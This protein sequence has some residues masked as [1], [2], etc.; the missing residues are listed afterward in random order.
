MADYQE[1]QKQKMANEGYCNKI[2]IFFDEHLSGDRCGCGDRALWELVQNAC[3]QSQEARVEIEL[4]DR[5]LIFKHHGRAFDYESFYSLVKQDSSKD[6]NADDAEKSV[7]RYG[8]G[9]MTTHTFNKLVKVSG[10]YIVKDYVDGTGE[11]KEVIIRGHVQI[12]DFELDRT[13]IGTPE[14]PSVMGRQLN[15]VDKFRDMEMYSSIIDNTTSFRYDL[16]PGQVAIVSR[17]LQ[18]FVR[19][20]PFVFIINPR[21]ESVRIDDTFSKTHLGISRS[22]YHTRTSFQH[23]GWMKEVEEVIIK[24]DN[25]P[26]YKYHAVHTL[27]SDKGDVIVIPPF[28]EPSGDPRDLPSLFLWFPLLG[29][30]KFGM[31]FIFHSARFYPV[32]KRDNIMLPGV[33][34]EA[35]KVQGVKNGEIIKEMTRALFKYYEYE[36]SAHASELTMPFCEVSFPTTSNDSK[37]QEFYNELQRMWAEVLPNWP[38]IPTKDGKVKMTNQDVKLL[39]PDF[40]AKLT[41]EDLAKNES[42]LSGYAQ[43]PTVNNAPYKFP[44]KDLVKWSEIVDKWRCNRN[45][46]FFLSPRDVCSAIKQEKKGDDL[47]AFLSLLKLAGKSDIFD[48]YPVFPNRKGDLRYKGNLV[49][50]TFMDASVYGLVSGLMGTDAAK[51]VDTAYLDICSFNDYTVADLQKSISSTIQ[52]WRNKFL[53]VTSKESLSE[54]EQKALLGFCSAF[55]QDS[56]TNLRS[57]LVPLIAEFM[58]K[59][60]V[61][62]KTI[63]FLPQDKDEEDFYESAFSFLIDYTLRQV[64]LKDG[65]WVK[66]KRQWLH[67]FLSAYEPDKSEDKKKKLD[68]YGVLPNQHDALCK[69]GDLH[70]NKG[71]PLD[72]VTFYDAV[73]KKNPTEESILPGTWIDAGFEDIITLTEDTPEAIAKVIQEALVADMKQED[74]A[75]RKFSAVVRKIILK[76]AKD[77]TWAKWFDQIDEKKAK[78]V[79]EMKDGAAQ[80]SLFKLMDLDNDNLE[81]LAAISAAPNFG[82]LIRMAR[83]QYDKEEE[84][85][86][87]FRFTY[88]IGKMIENTVRAEVSEELSCTADE[89]ETDDFQ[90]GQD[91]KILYRGEVLY[92]LECKAKWNFS[93][94]AHMSSQQ[95][96]QA[97]RKEDRYALLCV[98]CTDSTGAHVPLDATVEQLAASREDILAHTY[99]HTGIGGLLSKT[100][101]PQV[102]HED[103]QS[104]DEEKAIRLYSL[105]SCNIPKM[106]FASGESFSVFITKLKQYLKDRIAAIHSYRSENC[107]K[108]LRPSDNS[109]F[110]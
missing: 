6:Q 99:A 95:M 43:L 84:E 4:N 27:K 32:E 23:E 74:V 78:Y 21:L 51:I 46:E 59:E 94:P 47:H 41:E 70:K 20:L 93:E 68:T 30:E 35:R 102:R 19:L 109:Y 56:P 28:P 52:Q 108:E 29:T 25:D 82:E 100:I 31:N 3:D 15:L 13:R 8:T 85:R 86:R 5:S 45:S 79:F 66:G 39:H 22:R 18:G 57:K 53:P 48:S 1:V 17:Q 76:M 91:M 75:D 77:A 92:Y 106:V 63:R 62:T 2:K 34:T 42:I 64:S 81:D 65:D 80:E 73:F 61:R 11:S 26:S 96:K 67:N 33:S 90:N 7:G 44:E 103:D 14:A 40:Y 38:V 83:D 88:A 107:F 69:K 89:I 16:T 49:N 97:A 87:Q 9:F 60:Y 10:P 12:R 58:G 72:M 50:P 37:E 55:S 110:A 36:N 105:L 24:H 54:D 104:L 101:G 71:V 98:D